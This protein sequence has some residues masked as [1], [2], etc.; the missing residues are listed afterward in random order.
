M[1]DSDQKSDIQGLQKRQVITV[2]SCL[3]KIVLIL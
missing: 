2:R 3:A 1:S